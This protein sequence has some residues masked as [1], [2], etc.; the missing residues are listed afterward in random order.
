MAV[1]TYA[2]FYDRKQDKVV[3]R[4]NHAGLMRDY[5][6]HLFKLLGHPAAKSGIEAISYVTQILTEEQIKA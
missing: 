6:D 2:V 5:P 4:I 1:K 3:A